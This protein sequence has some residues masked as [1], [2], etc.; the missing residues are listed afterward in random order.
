MN[1]PAI[2]RFARL[3]LLP[4]ELGKVQPEEYP[5]CPCCRFVKQKKQSVQPATEA[6]PSIGAQA[7]QPG[8]V[9]SVDMIYSP[10]GG[11]IPVAKGKTLEEKYHIECVFV[12]QCTKLVYITYQ[13]STSAV[14]TVEYEHA[15]EKWAATHG[16]K[17]EHYR[18]DNGAFNTRFF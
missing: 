17:I 12:D 16:I 5:I 13:I 4:K 6:S 3:N 18:A 9:I 11:L 7:E 10:V 1:Y 14:E 2:Q 8:D 15:F